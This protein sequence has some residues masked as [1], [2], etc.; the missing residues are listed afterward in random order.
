[1]RTCD[2]KDC[3]KKHSA[4]GYCRKHHTRFIRNGTTDSLYDRS[5]YDPLDAIK[6]TREGHRG[7]YAVNIINDI[8]F[9]AIKRK[10]DWLLTHQ[11]AFEIIKSPCHYCGIEPNWPNGRVGIDRTDNAVGYTFENCAPCCFTCNS[12]KGIMG[13]EKF[14]EW[15]KRIH[16]H[17]CKLK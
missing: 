17:F 3:D 15:I 14:R 9:K 1:M 7:N 11:Q 13:K 6:D 2:V 8:K 16:E 10:K 4:L 5:G 12:A